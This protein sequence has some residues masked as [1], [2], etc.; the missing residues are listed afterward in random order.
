M[1]DHLGE[2]EHLILLAIARLRDDAYG[3]NIRDTLEKRAGRGASFG[4]IYSTLRRLERKGLIRSVLGTPEPV[5]GG[6]AKKYVALTARGRLAV[7]ES[8][9]ALLRMADGLSELRS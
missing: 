6:R 8:H 4:A 5:R 7:R 2:F 9:S 1:A 3:V